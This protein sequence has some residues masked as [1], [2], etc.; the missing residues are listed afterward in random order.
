MGG[1]L[2]RS[3][4]GIG[5]SA[6]VWAAVVLAPTH[7]S[8]ETPPELPPEVPPSADDLPPPQPEA[9]RQMD[10][11]L[12]YREPSLDIDVRGR[13]AATIVSEAEEA[14]LDPLLVLAVIEV[15]SSFDAGAL[16]EAGAMGLMQLRGPTLR[17]ELR[18]HGLQGDLD[19]PVTN[20]QAGVRYLRRLMNAFPAEDVALMAYNAGPNRIL[21]YMRAGEIPDRFRVY[22]RRVKAVLRRLHREAGVA[23]EQVAALRQRAPA[24]VPGRLDD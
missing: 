20:V 24:A 11:L 17:S 2:A 16:S 3:V 8:R 9:F 6:A 4:A 18:R 14:N 10:E 22:P 12:A 15:E 21:G 13:L 7:L 1:P 5:V 23:G 19:D